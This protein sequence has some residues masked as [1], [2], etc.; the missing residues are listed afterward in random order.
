MGNQAEI[1]EQNRRPAGN[2]AMILDYVKIS[3]PSIIFL[4]DFVAISALL[5]SYYS[6]VATS[7]FPPLILIGSVL[8]AGQRLPIIG[9]ISMD[10][11]VVDITG[12]DGVQVGD[13]ATLIGTDGDGVITLDEVAGLAGTISYEILTGFTTR[14][15]RI[16][17]TE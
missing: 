5:V 8:L 10:V 2:T 7:L 3:K 16:W 11:T 14:M 4:L 1:A 12:V 17:I 9:R 6:N 13:A 15:P